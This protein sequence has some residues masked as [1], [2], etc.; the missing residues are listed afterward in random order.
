[1]NWR[2][3]VV[4]VMVLGV[5]G[6]V[7]FFYYKSY[8]KKRNYGIVLFVVNG[9]DNDLLHRARLQT[10][11]ARSRAT[12]T[13]AKPG[14]LPASAADRA[15]LEQSIF[16]LESWPHL[17]M[18]D[19]QGP[20]EP[21]ADEGAL[22]TALACGQRVPNGMISCNAMGKP[23]TTLLQAAQ[24]RGRATGLITTGALTSPTALAFYTGQK[25][26]HDPH[27]AAAALAASGV[28]LI[29]GGG[30][31]YFEPLSVTNERG[32]ADR[33]NLVA[34]C[35]REGYTVVR[36]RESLQ[37]V[38]AWRTGKW[39][40]LFA[41]DQ[42]LFDDVATASSDQPS[43]ADMTR[44]AIECLNYTLNGYFLVIEH[45]LVQRAA[46][47]NFTALAID[48]V[49]AFDEALRVARN[50]AGGD[51]LIVVTNSF[52][53]GTQA[54]SLAPLLPPALIGQTLASASGGK[55]KEEPAQPK[56]QT[57][58]KQGR[59]KANAP[60]TLPSRK[61]LT[62]PVWLT[63]P[64]AVPVTAA[65]RAWQQRLVA[66]GTFQSTMGDPRYPDVAARF[67]QRARPTSEPAW[68]A[69]RGLFS[70]RFS[71][72]MPNTRVYDLLVECF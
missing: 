59:S 41:D 14:M 16:H 40:G 29:F 66:N 32:R 28:N 58:S 70:E 57:R 69:A 72:F 13:R 23:L 27:A 39:L 33:R 54:E 17:A 22:A 19:V 11:Q 68:L 53:L 42:M 61:L 30:G 1:M 20:G 37:K 55:D 65:Q 24:A 15:L 46:E 49:E 45:N 48:E 60:S 63:G 43:L 71:G 7:A 2:I 44:R 8:V 10:Q 36:D 25:G 6:A 50:Y 34:E 4:A 26:A 52:S 56:W 47:N 35:Q 62:V 3:P 5:F 38:A 51:A 64:G 9:L 18:L 12:L 67:S 21:V 31:R